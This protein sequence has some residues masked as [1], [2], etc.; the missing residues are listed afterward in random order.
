MVT[1]RRGGSLS[2]AAAQGIPV[3][4]TSAPAGGTAALGIQEDVW[5]ESIST[6]EQLERRL[7]DTLPQL[8]EKQWRA[9]S[10]PEKISNLDNHKTE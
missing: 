10:Y 7:E 6:P 1:R 2:S 9:S 5:T 8:S 4:F 3:I